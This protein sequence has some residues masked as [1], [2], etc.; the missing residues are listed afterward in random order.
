AVAFLAY[1]GTFPPHSDWWIFNNKSW[2]TERRLPDNRDRDREK[3]SGIFTHDYD[4]TITTAHL[5]IKGGAVE[6]EIEGLTDKLF[7]AK[8]TS[9]IGTHHL[10]TT[11]DGSNVNLSFQMKDTKKSN[12]NGD[13]NSAKIS[14]NG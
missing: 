9:T 6:Y 3:S 4:S 13:E 8:A 2:D 11:T 14:L 5:N 1:R 7:S 10:E 12:W